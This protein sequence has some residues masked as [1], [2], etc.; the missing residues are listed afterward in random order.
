MAAAA[1]TAAVPYFHSFAPFT[2][3]KQFKWHHSILRSD[4]SKFQSNK[5]LTQRCRGAGAQRKN[6]FTF[7]R[8]LL[9]VPAALFSLCVK[10][11]V[12]ELQHQA[13]QRCYVSFRFGQTKFNT[14]INIQMIIDLITQTG[15]GIDRQLI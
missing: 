11:F 5:S 12:L 7:K 8:V 13:I 2:G 9:C 15:Q 1:T 6:V 10:D 4:F 3:S 14:G